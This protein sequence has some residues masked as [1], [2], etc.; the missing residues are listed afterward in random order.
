MNPQDLLYT[1]EFLTTSTVLKKEFDE[2]NKNYVRYK[3]FT[4]KNVTNETDQYINND[5]KEEDPFNINKRNLNKFPVGNNGNHYPLFD[6]YISDVS[7]DTY[8]KE[9]VTKLNIDSLLRD[10][11]VSPTSNN[12]T[13]KFNKVFNNVSKIVINNINMPN[14]LQSINI[15][16]NN[17][18]W[19]YPVW[20]QLLIDNTTSFIIPS[21]NKL[22]LIN[23]LNIANS[24]SIFDDPNILVYQTNIDP[25]SYTVNSLNLKIK[26]QTTAIYHGETKINKIEN[27]DIYTEAPYL[28]Y[29][30]LIKTPH[31]FR[32]DINPITSNVKIVN[33]MEE[34]SI[35]VF[36]T[37][38]PYTDNN[39]NDIFNP[40]SSEPSK[41]INPDYIYVILPYIKNIT[42]KY[43][44]VD[45]PTNPNQFQSPFPLV[46]TDLL[47]DIGNIQYELIKYTEFFDLNIYLSNGY[48]ENDV[49]SIP[50]YKYWDTITINS[51]KYYRFALKLSNGKLNGLYY[52]VEGNIIKPITFSTY[53]Y[54]TFIEKFFGLSSTQVLNANILIGRALLFRWIFDKDNENY[55]N[56]QTETINTKKRSILYTLS[57]PIAN[58]TYNQICIIQNQGYAFVQ[59]NN[60][61]MI[62]NSNIFNGLPNSEQQN[63][64]S[65]S[66]GYPPALNIQY[67]N[68]EYFFITEGYVYISLN[69]F[70][71]K[72]NDSFKDYYALSG[73]DINNQYNQ[74]YIQPYFN[75]GIGDNYDCN[76]QKVIGLGELK[77]INKENIYAKIQVSNIPNNIDNTTTNI[78]TNGIVIN[79]YDKPIDN[80]SEIDIVL[81]DS[82]YRQIICLRDF[83]FTLEVHEIINVLKETLIDSKRNNVSVTGKRNI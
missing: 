33:R 54:D 82:F 37:F 68:G 56:Y 26:Y 47:Q 2:N 64:L 22:N 34:V 9:Y 70:S 30:K 46:I 71:N 44:N 39:D 3:N 40:Y 63:L 24:C 13:L 60:N 12:F 55:I 29:P 11:T 51:I 76:I 52:N 79:N 78:N 8:E 28:I 65:K 57:W 14:P 20:S 41:I 31:L 53:I 4:D 17:I 66:I 81:V 80:F 75:V 67:Q 19:Q 5:S 58:K 15:Y 38:T 42:D 23:F 18:A 59:N 32:L 45:D 6:S 1:N 50:T 83:S 48:T 16:N 62:M 27:T 69:L 43:F 49:I 35:A 36:Q 77:S 73:S 61:G 25:G 72:S 21:P 74:N 10:R 7:K